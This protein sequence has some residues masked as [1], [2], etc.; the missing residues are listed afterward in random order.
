MLLP[1]V[2]LPQLYRYIIH[3]TGYLN[4]GAEKCG[5]PFC[6]SMVL[7]FQGGA[8][9][10]EAYVKGDPYDREPTHDDAAP[11]GCFGYNV[12]DLLEQF[13]DIN[14]P[15]DDSPGRKANNKALPRAK[16]SAMARA[17]AK[18]SLVKRMSRHHK[19]GAA[20]V[21]HSNTNTEEVDWTV[22]I[23]FVFSGQVEI[24][25]LGQRVDYTRG[26]MEYV[27]FYAD[28]ASGYE[29]PGSTATIL[30]P[31]TYHL[32]LVKNGASYE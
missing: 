14:L 27:P 9:A 29:P 26:M 22:G 31:Y 1:L 28:Y 30:E 32:A 6:D 18:T 12:T 13:P 10:M 4:G 5:Q 16:Q 2:L 19:K 11:Y 24:T 17:L 15:L 25:S 7:S 3:P 21:R 20:S 23:A 8:Y